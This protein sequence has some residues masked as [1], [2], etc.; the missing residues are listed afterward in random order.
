M[1]DKS[2]TPT[3]RPLLRTNFR[4]ISKADED[5][6]EARRHHSMVV[7]QHCAIKGAQFGSVASLVLGPPIFYL[8]GHRGG[9]LAQ[10]TLQLSVFGVAAGMLASE[11]MCYMILRKQPDEGVFD[12]AYRLSNSE[13]Q[14]RADVFSAVG[15]VTMAALAFRL[16][17]G[18]MPGACVGFGLGILAHC[19]Y[20][21]FAKREP[22]TT[23]A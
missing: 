15:A 3:D 18:Y 9:F 20:K 2:E 8:R 12:R 11:A 17:I 16:P 22:L 5:H 7:Y 10:K 23:A 14:N 13:S 4:L 19:A 21:P 1:P 6:P